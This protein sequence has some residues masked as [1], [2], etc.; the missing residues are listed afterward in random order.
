MRRSPL[1]PI[2]LT[3]F[4]DVL[5]LTLILPLLPYYAKDYGG[6][7]V[8]AGALMAVYAACMF[9]S[10]PVLGRLSDRFGRKPILLVSQLG[11]LAGW[12]IL[13]CSTSLE[14]LFVGR[15][16]A[17]LTA[18][19][20]SIAQAYISDVTKPNEER[21]Q[22]FGFFGI[23]FGTGFL[24]GPWISGLLT[25]FAKGHPDLMARYQVV[26][27]VPEKLYKYQ[28]PSLTAAAL[29]LCAILLTIFILPA[30]KPS[31]PAARR[32][33]AFKQFLSRPAPR[34]RLTEFFLFSLSFSALT[35]GLS[36]YLQHRFGFD[37]EH[38]G[39]IFGLSGL[40]GA[41]VQGG[42]LKRLARRLGEERLATVGL[43]A[44][45]LGNGLLGFA[46]SLSFLLV[47][48]VIGAFGAAVVRPSIT[49]LVTRTVSPPEQGSVLGVSQSLGSLAQI[50]GPLVA[51]WLIG[52]E[53]LGIYG[54]FCGGFSLLAL[55][56]LLQRPEPA[57]S[58]EAV[59]PAA[60]QPAPM[61]EAPRASA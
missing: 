38:A 46:Y 15:I 16:I 43:G 54:A 60:E 34:K 2:F 30:R 5:G 11:T 8:V 49:T 12:L 3:V 39:Y 24:L 45:A 14:M 61:Q 27:G 40:V 48:V 13:A 59:A 26:E 22:A 7:D 57:L 55:F 10:G 6:T 23:A 52:R 42:P 18:G 31:G 53:H 50:A 51:S 25:A 17:G 29:S 33:F 28:L 21:T 1:L 4:V 19:N 56:V 41:V 44:M 37:A 9:V 32:S 36:L 47:L 20:L 58:A 35:G